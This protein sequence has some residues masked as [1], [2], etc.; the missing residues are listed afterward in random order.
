VINDLGK[1]KGETKTN[2][3]DPQFVFYVILTDSEILSEL[4]AAD[5]RHVNGIIK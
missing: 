1:E 4:E 2:W 3:E 5:E